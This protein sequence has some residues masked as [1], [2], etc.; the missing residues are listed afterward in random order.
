[1]Q[2]DLLVVFIMLV[3]LQLALAFLVLLVFTILKANLD[4][5]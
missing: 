2:V 5:L 4:N 1:M 3:N